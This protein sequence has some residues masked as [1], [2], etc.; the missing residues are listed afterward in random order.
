M[1]RRTFLKVAAMGGSATLLSFRVAGAADD[2]EALLLSCM[3][4]R[5]VESTERYMA[6]RGLR[7]K[8]DHIVLAG[9]SLGAVTEKFPA[10]NKT[11]WEHL[12]V[13]VDLH[14]IQ[15]VVVLNHRDCGA[16]KLVFSE[17]ISK[18]RVRET[19]VHTT[20]LRELRKQIQARQ[21]KLT[22]ELDRKSVV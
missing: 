13:A 17:D 20:S 4:Y 10:W 5:L 18:D 14:H 22:V 16:Y 1:I 15:K 7:K 11:F 21:P 6:Q 8:Y 9:A 2:T 19:A 12:G 3:D